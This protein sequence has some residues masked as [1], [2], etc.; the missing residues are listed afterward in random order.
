MRGY[1]CM[2]WCPELNKKEGGK[3]NRGPESLHSLT[4]CAAQTGASHSPP[5]PQ[6]CTVT[7]NRPSSL[8][9]I[10]SGI[11]PAIRKIAS[12]QPVVRLHRPRFRGFL[13]LKCNVGRKGNKIIWKSRE[14]NELNRMSLSG[15]S[16]FFPHM[17]RHNKGS[18]VWGALRTENTSRNCFSDSAARLS[19]SAALPQRTQGNLHQSGASRQPC[20]KSGLGRQPLNVHY[21]KPQWQLKDAGHLW[22][23]IRGCRH[24]RCLQMSVISTLKHP[25]CLS[26]DN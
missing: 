23:V 26:N 4:L 5:P 2:D 6:A 19:L 7:P 12:T 13:Q 9:L 14:Q 21:A 16:F 15:D 24:R 11:I 8:K 22:E 25:S 18:G 1:H 20:L 3:L 10:W 17:K